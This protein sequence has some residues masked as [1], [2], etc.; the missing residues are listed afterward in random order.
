MVAPSSPS[1]SVSAPS[2]PSASASIH[3]RVTSVVLSPS[4][5]RVAAAD[6]GGSHAEAADEFTLYLIRHG[7]ATHNIREKEAQEAAAAEAAARG[8]SRDSAEVKQA[9]EQAR[10]AVLQDDSLRDPPLSAAGAAIATQTRAGLAELAGRGFPPPAVVLV[11]PLQRTLQTAAAVFPE[12]PNVRACEEIQERQTGLACDTRSP[13][14]LLSCRKTFEHI[15][16]EK[17]EEESE[18]ARRRDGVED[19]TML[20]ER[21]L[22]LLGLLECS[23][24]RSVALVTHKGYLRELE[25]GPFCRPD[26]TE[27]GNGEMR[28]YRVTISREPCADRPL[29]PD[30]VVTADRLFPLES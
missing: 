19:K 22:A 5:A 7:E 26:A 4:G 2:S 14:G 12:H 28:V 6:E 17:L 24:H 29:E 21:T 15:T 18:A 11:S 10:K 23:E 30:R 25:R 3:K 13:M 16:F 9:M 1:A 20:R 8:L 27:C